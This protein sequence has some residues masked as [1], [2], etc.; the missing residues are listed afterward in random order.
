MSVDPR[1]A[2]IS[3]PFGDWPL[4][5]QQAGLG[6]HTA[7]DL[8]APMDTPI[9]ATHDGKVEHVGAFATQDG[10]HTPSIDHGT[11]GIL[12]AHQEQGLTQSLGLRGGDPVTAGQTIGL[13]GNKG[14]STGPHS[15]CMVSIVKMGNGFWDYARWNGGLV[16]PRSYLLGEYESGVVLDKLFSAPLSTGSNA[17]ATKRFVTVAELSLLGNHIKSV[18]ITNQGSW[19]MYVPGAP[20]IVNANFPKVLVAGAPVLVTVG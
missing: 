2:A 4:W 8:P 9:I 1:T 16:D 10:G 7:I 17:V 18:G 13:I 15:H 12:H 11:F 14:W 5:R 6:W 3:S 19:V 20:K